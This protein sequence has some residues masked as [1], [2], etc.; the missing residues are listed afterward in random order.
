[1]LGLM[2]DRPLAIPSI[3]DFAART[4][5]TTEIVSCS[6]DAPARRLTYA[7]L[8]A[9]AKQLAKALH[10]EL[11]VGL[12]DR[13][14]TLAWNDHRHLELYYAVAGIGAVCHTIN[15]RLFPEQIAYIINHAE[16]RYL[17]VDPMFL[18]L[19]A[20]LAPQLPSVER[21]FLLSDAEHM[22]P[23][24]P[25]ALGCYETLLA[26][27]DDQLAWP[28][29]DE[30][31][32]SG[33]CY[34][35]GTTGNPKGVLYHHRSTLLHALAICLP[36]SIGVTSRDVV[37]PVV[38]MFHVNAWGL[39]YA[40]PLVGTKLVMPGPKLDGASLHEVFEREQVTFSAGVPTIWLGLLDHLE[41]TGSR[42]SSLKRVIIG[43]A[44][45][46]AAMIERFER[47]HGVEV[48]HGWGMTEMSPVGTVCHMPRTMAERPL[49]EQR[50]L[51][52]K[53]GQA[54]WGV[55][56]KIVDAAGRPLPHDGQASGLLMCRGAWI[57][58]GYFRD[59]A[60]NEGAFDAE[61]WFAT[62]DVATIDPAGFLE[63]TDRAKDVIKSGG[64][65]I[66]S[67]A[68]ENLAIGHPAVAEAAVIGLAH[69][70][71]DER[72]LLVVV[73]RPGSTADKAALLDHLRGR[74]AS[75]WVPDDVMIVDQLP[76]TATGKV[77]KSVLREQF[78]GHAWPAA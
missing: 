65:W 16:D 67:I 25:L 33:L 41:R 66:S 22:P 74:V 1:M 7:Q 48:M 76:H 60:S 54:L 4:H 56:L 34:T 63:I 47:D 71:W 26:G 51:K 42:L 55:E 58:S 30:R 61:G 17:F 8:Q 53:Q 52:Q 27:H 5:G 19:I 49:E 15:P 28:E 45:A 50:R 75:W 43:G 39:P 9:R 3:I 38:P 37:L 10:D 12:G 6:V 69:P 59:E 11:G 44:A 46:P 57:T 68:L 78:A 70:K 62:G 29:L 77:Q 2:M 31:T 72:P 35:S 14:G 40:C 73:L 64:E 18:P 13:I 23:A 36:G 20:K 21:I 32:A 24:P